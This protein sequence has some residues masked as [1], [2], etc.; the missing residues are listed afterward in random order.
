VESYSRKKLDVFKDPA[1]DVSLLINFFVKLR[2]YICFL[3]LMLCGFGSLE[4][5]FLSHPL[6]KN[7][8]NPEISVGLHLQHRIGGLTDAGDE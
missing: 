7:I 6:P 3:L 5:P 1:N 4:K 2:N 8:S